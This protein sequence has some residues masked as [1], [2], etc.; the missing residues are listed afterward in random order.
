[1]VTKVWEGGMGWNPP[2]GKYFIPDTYPQGVVE[3]IPPFAED[4]RPF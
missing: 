4:Y 3:F 1:M 2:L